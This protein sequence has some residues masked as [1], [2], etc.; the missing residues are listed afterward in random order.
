MADLFDIPLKDASV[1]VVYTSHS[2]EPNGG[3]EEDAIRELMRIA[4]RAVILVEPIYELANS[5]AQSR[6]RTHG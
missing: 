5:E 6:M 1:D 4:R 3:L 2:H